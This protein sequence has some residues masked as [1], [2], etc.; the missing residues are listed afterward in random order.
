MN[1]QLMQQRQGPACPICNYLMEWTHTYMV[2]DGPQHGY[3]CPSC[4]RNYTVRPEN[5]RSGMVTEKARKEGRNGLG[6]Y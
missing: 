5:Q 4:R 6:R 3:Q 2:Q 1:K